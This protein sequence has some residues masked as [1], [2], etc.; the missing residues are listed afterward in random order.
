MDELIKRSDA[1]EAIKGVK[2]RDPLYGVAVESI[3]STLPAVNAWNDITKIPPPI[4]SR[5]CI[6]IVHHNAIR[7]GYIFENQYSKSGYALDTG[8]GIWNNVTHWI[9]VPDKPPREVEKDD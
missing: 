8:Y 6:C 5:V 9:P 1:L 4:P 3:L 7:T 2:A